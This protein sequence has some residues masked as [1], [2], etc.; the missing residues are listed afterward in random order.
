MR[1][2]ERSKSLNKPLFGELQGS[3][4]RN[5]GLFCAYLRIATV[6]GHHRVTVA[7]LERKKLTSLRILDPLAYRSALV[8]SPDPHTIVTQLLVPL[9]SGRLRVSRIQSGDRF[10]RGFSRDRYKSLREAGRRRGSEVQ[11]FRLRVRT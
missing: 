8:G 4:A 11:G 7:D 10:C 1:R 5:E 6:D 3:F 2:P 9:A